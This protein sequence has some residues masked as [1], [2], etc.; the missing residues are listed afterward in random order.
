[1]AEKPRAV[2]VFIYDG[3]DK[4]SPMTVNAIKSFLASTPGALP[5]IPLPAAVTDSGA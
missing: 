4:Y 2:A 3:S 1:M 5:W